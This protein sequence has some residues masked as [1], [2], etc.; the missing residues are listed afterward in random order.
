MG[1][2]NCSGTSVR[3]RARSVGFAAGQSC[4]GALASRRM[5]DAPVFARR[6]TGAAGHCAF[7]SRAASPAETPSSPVRP[8]SRLRPILEAI[9]RVGRAEN[10]ETCEYEHLS[11]EQRV[12]VIG[13][14]LAGAAECRHEMRYTASRRPRQPKCAILA[15]KSG[16][17]RDFAP[18]IVR[19]C[20]TRC[21]FCNANESD[22]VGAARNREGCSAPRG[23]LASLARA[24][25]Q[26]NRQ[27]R[28]HRPLARQSGAPDRGAHHSGVVG[29]GRQ[30]LATQRLGIAA[31][32]ATV[33]ET[34][35]ARCRRSSERSATARI[36]QA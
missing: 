34:T 25:V 1:E 36:L 28:P 31:Q 9:S 21:A 5:C 33:P 12:P 16:Y 2:V 13:D 23:R 15:N 11:V 35:I 26:L 7:V 3:R 19:P 18:E 8:E 4:G 29:A 17:T 6:I 24:A 27:M 10:R 14:R 32:R 22:G 30:T 20:R